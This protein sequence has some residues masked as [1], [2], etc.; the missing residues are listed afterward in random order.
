MR[1]ECDELGAHF[2]HGEACPSQGEHS[3]VAIHELHVG[4]VSLL[5]DCRVRSAKSV[6]PREHSGIT[7]SI[8]RQGFGS[9]VKALFGAEEIKVGDTAFDQEWFIQSN[10]PDFLAAGLLPEM[11]RK[12]QPHHD[13]WKLEDGEIIYS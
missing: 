5:V 8:S 7:F 10:A 2:S 3:D 4:H 6:A 12:I 1:G 11:Q 13:K 9:R